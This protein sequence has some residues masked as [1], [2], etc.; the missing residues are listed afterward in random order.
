MED[1]VK[2]LEKLIDIAI[3]DAWERNDNMPNIQVRL[4]TQIL[5]IKDEKQT[6]TI[7]KNQQ[8][9]EVL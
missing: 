2:E 5:N 6:I 3:E 1:K 7:A 9:Y 8:D 4:L